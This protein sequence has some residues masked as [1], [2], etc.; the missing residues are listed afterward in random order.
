M[1]SP[2]TLIVLGGKSN[3][4]VLGGGQICPKDFFGVF[5]IKFKSKTNFIRDYCR[6]IATMKIVYEHS[7]QQNMLEN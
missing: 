1:F 5:I 7:C 2:L 6:K 4:I 3:L